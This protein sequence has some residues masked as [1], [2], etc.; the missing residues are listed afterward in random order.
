MN[1]LTPAGS[2]ILALLTVAATAQ[3][4]SANRT[5]S[6]TAD[7]PATSVGQPSRDAAAELTPPFNGTSLVNWMTLDGQPVTR[8]WEVVGGMIHLSKGK[9]RSGHIVTRDEYGDF[10]LS[11]EWKIAPGGNSGLKYRV[12]KYGGKVLGCEYQIFDDEK[13]A[14]SRPRPKG[15][16]G[17]LYDLYEP[18]GAKQLK[19]AGEFNTARIVVQG[20]H[21]EHWL[22]GRQIVTATVGDDQWNRAVAESKFSDASDFARNRTGRIMLTDHGS[23]VWYR[24]I[25]FKTLP[26]RAPSAASAAGAEQCKPPSS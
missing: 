23:E 24:N 6:I 26:T 11:F 13:N 18:N 8:G 7:P 1:P 4:S 17:A 25:Q 12:R 16:A 5:P 15:S 20:D 2:L 21:I 3:D 22:N 10:D 14:K 19:P 9:G